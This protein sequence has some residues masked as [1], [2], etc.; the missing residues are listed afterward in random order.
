MLSQQVPCPHQAHARSAAHEHA[1]VSSRCILENRTHP[2]PSPPARAGRSC[3]QYCAE[4]GRTCK[5]A[6]E[7]VSDSVRHRTNFAP[8][9]IPSAVSPHDPLPQPRAR[10]NVYDHEGLCGTRPAQFEAVSI[11]QCNVE[12]TW[13]CNQTQKMFGEQTSDVICEC[14]SRD[15]TPDPCAAQPGGGSLCPASG[16]ESACA[17]LR[18]HANCPGNCKQGEAGCLACACP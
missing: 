6:W 4:L 15:G 10:S 11:S 16:N 3:T 2:R 12:E 18:T 8:W 1:P 9:L 7:E 13:S 14:S 5:G 17:G